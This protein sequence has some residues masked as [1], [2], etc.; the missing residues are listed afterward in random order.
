MP[1]SRY[2]IQ[3]S[4]DLFGERPDAV[5]DVL[6]HLEPGLMLDVGA[7]A[8]TFTRR[9]L[10]RSPASRVVAFEPFPGNHPFLD[11]TV[12]RDPR[13]T[14]VK[15]AV[16]DSTRPSTFKVGK[17]VVGSEPGWERMV[18]YS[19]LGFVV[20]PDAA[21]PESTIT[22][23][24]ARIDDY[25]EPAGVRFLKIDVQGGELGV[26]ESARRSLRE[27]LIDILFVEFAGEIELV[28]FIIDHGF[29]VFDSEYL[30]IPN[31]SPDLSAWHT[32]RSSTLSTGRT[33]TRGWPLELPTTPED[34]CRMF[35]AERRKV[36]TIQTDLVC[37]RS[38]F[39]DVFLRAAGQAAG[40]LK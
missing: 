30:L 16:A 17:T 34:Y 9:M 39:V 6:A 36:G 7:A 23:P 31:E 40:T 29:D 12:G 21:V 20:D 25:V 38:D 10:D 3:S 8:G 13:V 22:V 2:E 37:V 19:S 14:I 35:A 5:Y 1:A 4:R 33:F 11:D 32:F 26:L 27:R 18:G 15:A 28:R 24:T